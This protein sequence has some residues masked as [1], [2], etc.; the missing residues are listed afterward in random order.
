MPIHQVAANFYGIMLLGQFANAPAP[1]GIHPLW[2]I[3]PT[4]LALVA[5]VLC[6]WLAWRVRSMVRVVAQLKSD[7]DKPIEVSGSLGFLPRFKLRTLLILFTISAVLLGMFAAEFSRARRQG[8][9]LDRLSSE[10]VYSDYG[11]AHYHLGK[12][13]DSKLAG[14]ICD[15]VHPHFGCRLTHLSLDYQTEDMLVDP[16]MDYDE[17]T[18]VANLRDLEHLRVAGGRWSLDQIRALA[19]LPKLKSLS[20]YVARLPPKAISELS[21]LKQLRKLELTGCDLNDE[22]MVG[23]AK[24]D[25]LTH[26]ALTRNDLGDASMGEVAR[27]PHLAVLM[28]GDNLVT[29]EGVAKL[30]SMPSLTHI[31]FSG[32][33]IDEKAASYLADLPNLQYVNFAKI[34][35]LWRQK[36]IAEIK[37]LLE[38]NRGIAIDWN[39]PHDSSDAWQFDDNRPSGPYWGYNGGAFGSPSGSGFF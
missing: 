5:T 24:L 21:K 3:A 29:S 7:S 11:S 37:D 33:T 19:T 2:L 17:I 30:A 28:L 16:V 36:K 12:L 39:S 9:T 32:T 31:D 18:A 26:L 14:L 1:T 34:P 20:L 6:C 25:G 27:L 4:L 22:D 38:E 23:I 13:G 15:W 35:N 8:A 10:H